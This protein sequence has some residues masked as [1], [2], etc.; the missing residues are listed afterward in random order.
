M[1]QP[2]FISHFINKTVDFRFDGRPLSFHLSQSLFSSHDIDRGS[3]LLLKTLA[4]FPQLDQVVS[5]LDVGCGVGVLGICLKKR[6]PRIGFAF[7][8]RDALALS[9]TALN[10]QLNQ[11]GDLDLRHDLALEGLNGQ[12]F[13]LIISNLPGKA[14][15]TVLKQIV[16]RMP[17]FLTATGRAAVVIVKPLAELVHSAL[18]E[19]GHDLLLE[20]RG[21]GHSVFH[22]TGAMGP[23]DESTLSSYLRGESPFPI[24][25]QIVSLKTVQNLPEFD[26]LAYQ[27]RLA[28]RL[29]EN[30]VV[31]GKVL[32][33]NPGQGYL[34]VKLAT[35]PS[36]EISHYTLAGR[37]LLSLR[38]SELNLLNHG[39]PSGHIAC[40]HVPHI[41]ELKDG[42]DFIILAPDPDPGVPWARHLLDKSASLLRPG[43][44]LLL[45]AKSSYAHRLL[46]AKH[47]LRLETGKRRHGF[48][49]QLLRKP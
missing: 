31:T 13:D 22:F 33:W 39:I 16:G 5:A 29:V 28:A 17:G 9:F 21:K 47:G 15:P 3:R 30:I 23:Q 19:H 43:G 4:G 44:G 6:Y 14:G 48:R 38:I 25:K 10:A 49:S 18:Q 11:I 46:A 26:T 2:G 42:Y 45:T 7:Q 34:A 41:M 12:R 36:H 40:S 37:D 8:D 27:T 32:V 24:G 20:E 1:S 35:S